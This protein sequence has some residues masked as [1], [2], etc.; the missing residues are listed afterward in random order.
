MRYYSISFNQ[1]TISQAGGKE[2]T[3]AYLLD[4]GRVRANLHY[5]VCWCDRATAICDSVNRSP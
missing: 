3:D 1:R 4:G 5:V 2:I